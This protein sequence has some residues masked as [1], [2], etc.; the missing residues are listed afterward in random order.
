M[1]SLSFHCLPCK[2]S[3][4][5]CVLGSSP[6]SSFPS[7]V[8]IL[9][10]WSCVCVICI[11]MILLLSS[12]S[13]CV[14]FPLVVFIIT[15]LCILVLLCPSPSL[16]LHVMLCIQVVSNLVCCDKK[17]EHLPLPTLSP[18]LNLNLSLTF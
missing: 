10:H 7:W 15:L 17:L 5:G 1:F 14:C 16:H 2:V 9:L 8:P 18:C 4:L 11:L 3:F 13:Y 12:S 6:S